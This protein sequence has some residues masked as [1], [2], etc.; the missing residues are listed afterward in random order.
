MSPDHAGRPPRALAL[1]AAGVEK[2]LGRAWLARAPLP[3]PGFV[4]DP[5]LVALLRKLMASSP[6]EA[7]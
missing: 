6:A 5:R 2:P 4:P 7:Q 3:R 1:L